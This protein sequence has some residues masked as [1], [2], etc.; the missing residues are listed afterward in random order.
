MA[1]LLNHLMRR[2]SAALALVL[3]L[4][5]F[6]SCSTVLSQLP[7]SMGGEPAGTPERQVTPAVYPAVHDMPPPRTDAVLTEKQR[8]E[9]TSELDAIRAKQAK[10]VE[11]AKKHD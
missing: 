3:A 6:A 1:T 11:E 5:A 9:A 2:R 10:Q 8:Q 7:E 4:P